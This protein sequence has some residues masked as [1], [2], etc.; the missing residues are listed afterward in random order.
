MERIKLVLLFVMNIVNLARSYE[1]EC[2]V[3]F[4]AM[5]LAV[6]TLEKSVTTSSVIE[7][8]RKSFVVCAICRHDSAF[9]SNV[10]ACQAFGITDFVSEDKV[11]EVHSVNPDTEIYTF[12]THHSS[13]GNEY[14]EDVL[15]IF[16]YKHNCRTL[17]KGFSYENGTTLKEEAVKLGLV[18]EE[19]FD[20]VVRPE[21]MIGPKS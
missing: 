15:N 13:C 9:V 17:L 1:L 21:Q 4:L 2:P 10:E 7:G 6:D 14:E 20:K 12:H 11:N 18:D 19:T 5:G 3:G 16:A 8:S